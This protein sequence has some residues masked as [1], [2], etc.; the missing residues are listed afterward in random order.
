MA[1]D[2][3]A[4]KNASFVGSIPEIYDRYLGPMLFH[5]Y[6][7]DLAAR[8]R[9]PAA[10]A[11]KVLELAAGT[12]ILTEQ[13]VARMPAGVQLTVTDL[14]PPMLAVAERRMEGTGRGRE[15][16]W[17]M[18]DATTLPFPDQSF[19]AV[20]CQ[21]GAMFFPDKVQA[22]REAYR[23]LRPGGQW[24]FNVWGS[25]AENRFASLVNDTI[26]GFFPA[27]P[28]GFYRVPF[29]LHDPG[30]LRSLVMEAGFPEPTITELR[31]TSSAPSAAH[32]A[33][34]LV[35]GNPVIAAIEERG[36]GSAEQIVAAV[37]AAL[38]R[39]FGDKPLHFPTVARVVEVG[40]A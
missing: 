13:L 39:E 23:V 18:A 2:S 22:F 17:Q 14:N 9:W 31:E 38:T 26:T 3:S 5:G 8:V 36:T 27:D 32:A 21:F 4:A 20:V 7:V 28:P 10:G 24:L 19:D 16:V 6:A 35:R 12:G 40:R 15:I 34:G 25:W 30:T 33:E 11:G 37:A 29:G 1:E